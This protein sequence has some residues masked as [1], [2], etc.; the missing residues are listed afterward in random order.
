MA[1]KVL[2]K[3][4][5]G[6]KPSNEVNVCGPKSGDATRPSIKRSG[7]DHCDVAVERDV[8]DQMFSAV[9][10]ANECEE[11]IKALRPQVEEAVQELIRQ[12]GLP[13]NY[14]GI[15]DYH[16]F[17]IRVQRP[18]SS[19]WHLNTQIQDP[20]LDFYKQLYKYYEQLQDSLKETRADLKRAGEK[21]EKAHPDSESIKYGFTIALMQ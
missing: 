7:I 13:R 16:G 6:R 3:E 12:R 9:L 11:Q 1:K 21:L 20:N 5:S 10:S 18:K 2:S 17:K 15:L 4:N 14:T 8:I 19:T